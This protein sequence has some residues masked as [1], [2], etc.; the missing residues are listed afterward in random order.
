MGIGGYVY[1]AIHVLKSLK[2][3]CEG[4]I[5]MKTQRVKCYIALRETWITET[6]IHIRSQHYQTYICI[7]LEHYQTYF[8]IGLEHY[9][10]LVPPG[11]LYCP[12]T[13]PPEI[14]PPAVL[15][16][17]TSPHLEQH[18]DWRSTTGIPASI[19]QSVRRLRVE[20]H[21]LQRQL[22]Q[23]SNLRFK[24]KQKTISI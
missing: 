2:I 24:K 10:C 21:H 5:T 8:R 4:F 17:Y 11:P 14:L 12:A 9:L 16:P 7:S 15:R 20:S 3:K 22:N 1:L 13:L 6:Y 23:R 19:S 18:P